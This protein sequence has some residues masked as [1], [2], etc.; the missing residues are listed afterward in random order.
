MKTKLMFA[1]AL[2]LIVSAPAVAQVPY[3]GGAGTFTGVGADPTYPAQPGGP[4]DIVD[5]AS[6]SGLYTGDGAYALND[7]AFT[8]GLNRNDPTTQ[9]G[10]FNLTGLFGGNPFSYA[11]NYTINIATNDTLTIGGNFI[12]V[13]GT[14]VFLRSLTLDNVAIGETRTGTLVAAVGGAVP[15]PASWALMIAGFGLAGYAMRRRKVTT[16]VTYA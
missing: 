7:V 6:R 5:F 2:A 4:F 9:S 3:S 13:F 11:V 16:A 10:V 1:S 15:E 14:P 12:D 8:V